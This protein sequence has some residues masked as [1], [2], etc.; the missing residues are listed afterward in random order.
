MHR[1]TTAMQNNSIREREQ[2]LLTVACQRRMV[3]T[4][5]VEQTQTGKARGRG[6]ARVTWCSKVLGAPA[7]HE[8][9]QQTQIVENHPKNKTGTY[10]SIC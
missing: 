5:Y 2:Y 1:R 10:G 8:W 6:I 4:C 3:I 7:R 9:L